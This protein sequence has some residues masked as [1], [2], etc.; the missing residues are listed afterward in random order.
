MRTGD[1]PTMAFSRRRFLQSGAAVLGTTALF[2]W[3]AWAQDRARPALRLHRWFPPLPAPA[4]LWVVPAV[5][6]VEEGMI[7]ESAAGLAALGIL[8]GYW[9]ALIYEDVANDGYQR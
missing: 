4:N 9:N 7:L 6:D 5:A 1:K 8:R 3:P 2:G